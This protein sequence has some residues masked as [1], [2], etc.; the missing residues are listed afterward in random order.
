M[1]CIAT[2]RASAI[3]AFLYNKRRQFQSTYDLTVPVEIFRC[4][5]PS[6][7]RVCPGGIQTQRNDEK[8]RFERFNTLYSFYQGALVTLDR[9]TFRQ[10]IVLIITLACSFPGLIDESCKVWIGKMRVAVD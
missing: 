2:Q 7:G 1:P 3:S 4:E 5:L 6:A 8:C 10:R 9:D